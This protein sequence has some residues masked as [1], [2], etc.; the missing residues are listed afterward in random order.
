MYQASVSAAKG[1]GKILQNMAASRGTLVEEMTGN[2]GFLGQSELSTIL[3]IF[4]FTAE[5]FKLPIHYP[6]SHLYFLYSEFI[7]LRNTGAGRRLRLNL[8]MWILC[9]TKPRCWFMNKSQA[10]AALS[11]DPSSHEEHTSQRSEV[12]GRN[13]G[14]LYQAI[15][16]GFRSVL[17]KVGMQ[18]L[19]NGV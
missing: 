14:P 15:P 7:E 1:S 4:A 8:P 9:N 16:A 10:I 5:R 18:G 12:I 3:Y 13:S 11:W 2:R 17:L 19:L 6:R